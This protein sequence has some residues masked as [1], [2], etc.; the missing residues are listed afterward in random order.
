[1]HP[2]AAKSSARVG[3]VLILEHV[4]HFGP[5]R[6]VPVLQEG[7]LAM[8]V[9]RPTAGDLLPKDLSD[10]D[11]L[12]VL[13]GPEAGDDSAWS[14]AMN[15]E[16]IFLGKALDRKI[17]I[18]ALALGSQLLAASLGAKVRAPN[19]L[20]MG[21][22]ETQ[23]RPAASSDALLSGEGPR[24]TAFYWPADISELP[25]GAVSLASSELVEHQAFRWGTSVYGL[26]FHLEIKA[27]QILTLVDTFLDGPALQGE[28]DHVA[29]GID[30]HLPPLRDLGDRVLRRWVELVLARKP[31]VGVER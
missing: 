2:V 14:E 16:V 24:F 29:S 8:D 1:M 30:A 26:R 17:P 15:D 13:G 20:E 22:Q 7:A 21:W 10:V 5:A 19:Y 18:L 3:R 9:V 28:A 31:L 27:E 25:K 12:I 11:G 4:P 6:I 23:L